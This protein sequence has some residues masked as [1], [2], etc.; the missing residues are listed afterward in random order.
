M[1]DTINKYTYN[2]PIPGSTF[3]EFQ[4]FIDNNSK[5]LEL[6]IRKNWGD[7]PEKY[8]FDK[9]IKLDKFVKLFLED[10]QPNANTV[11]KDSGKLNHILQ[12]IVH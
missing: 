2:N 4:E 9:K 1:I 8:K 10:L 3:K 11:H 5:P 6:N 12:H 7:K